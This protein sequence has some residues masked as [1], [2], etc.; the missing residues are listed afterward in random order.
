MLFWLKKLIAYWLM[1]LPLCMVLL[2]VGLAWLGSVRH[3]RLGRRLI[4]AGLIL[5]LVLS[6]KQVGLALLRPLESAYP[7]IPELAAGAPVPAPL[8]ACRA[9]VVLGSG[10]SDAPGLSATQRLSIA[11]TARIV[12]GVRLARRLPGV[13]LIVSGPAAGNGRTHASVLA[14]AAVELGLAPERIVQIDTARDTDDEAQAVRLRL[15]PNAPIALVTSA[16][17][18]PRA[19]GLMRRAGLQPVPCPTDFLSP[20]NG[21]WRATDWTC[22]LTGLERST[23]A[24]YER[25]GTLWARWQGKI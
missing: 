16:R 22:D 1:P 2:A 25:L 20:A 9:I 15:G 13:P 19:V 4:L 14:A 24:V 23:W 6:N 7:P 8:A 21:E 10:H 17:H 3:P 5:L 11:A 12:E 18:M